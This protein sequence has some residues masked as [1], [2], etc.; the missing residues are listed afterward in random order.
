[1]ENKVIDGRFATII[2]SVCYWLGYQLKIGRAQLLH[3]ASL[4]YP[5]ADAITSEGISVNRI[6][7]EQ[8]HPIFKSK[9]I[10]LAIY[11]E[12]VVQPGAEKDDSQL[13]EVFELKL[14]KSKTAEKYS[15]EHQRIFDDVVRLAYYNMWCGKDCY[16]LMCGTYENFKSYFVEQTK[17]VKQEGNKNVVASKKNKQ[18]EVSTVPET[19]EWHPEGLYKDWFEFKIGE[20]KTI[21]FDNTTEEW[22]LKPFQKN[23]EP[24]LS[25]NTFSNT[26]TVKTTCVAISPAG[27]KNKTHAAGLWKIEGIG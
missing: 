22:G 15:D 21:T 8:L 12:S 2:E 19:E 6:V 25:T 11:S 26:I 1:M 24:R 16:F 9:K 4:R 5:I 18:L 14:A 13:I 7:L 23:Y 27:E 20:P 10:D 3:E 17:K